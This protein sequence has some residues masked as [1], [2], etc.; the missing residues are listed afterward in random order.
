[1]FIILCFTLFSICKCEAKNENETYNDPYYNYDDEYYDPDEIQDYNCTYPNTNKTEDG[2]CE[3]IDGYSGD[4]YNPKGCFK[5]PYNCTENAD[6]EYPGVCKCYYGYVGD[7]LNKCEL[8]IPELIGITP[9]FSYPDGLVMVNVTYKYAF[10]TPY[11]AYCRFGQSYVNHY[12]IDNNVITCMAPPRNPGKYDLSISFDER[13]WSKENFT[14]EYRDLPQANRISILSLLLVY[15]GILAVVSVILYLTFGKKSKYVPTKDEKE[16][17]L[18][19]PEK[20]KKR[21][22]RA[23]KTRKGKL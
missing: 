13:H 19:D 23:I 22:K 8:A 1:M 6:C 10:G 11:Q 14:F 3:C 16:P 15:L 4:P 7:G 18:I 9:K 5:C 20:P 12:S 17:F 2:F 21:K